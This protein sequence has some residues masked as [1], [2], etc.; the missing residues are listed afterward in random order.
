MLHSDLR[1]LIGA[2]QWQVAQVGANAYEVR[3]VPRDWGQARDESSFTDSFQSTYFADAVVRLVPV[4][5]I[6]LTAAGK[7]IEYINE[8]NNR[9]QPGA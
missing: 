3:Y 8:W 1:K 7:F 5:N 9:L 4:P 2:G 6:P